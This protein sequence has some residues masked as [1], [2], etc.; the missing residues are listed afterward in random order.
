MFECPKCNR[1]TDVVMHAERNTFGIC[2]HCQCYFW[3]CRGMFTH[4]LSVEEQKRIYEYW[5]VER[6]YR[7]IDVFALPKISN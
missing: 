6:K 7:Y 4:G 5:T 3:A 1:N 2:H